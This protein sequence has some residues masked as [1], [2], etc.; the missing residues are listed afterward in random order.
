[1]P[2]YV[3]DH[4]RP[5]VATDI[6]ILCLDAGDLRVLLV[7]RGAEPFRG[8]WALPGGFLQESEDLDAC[9][10]RETRE[11]TGVRPGRILQFAN[12]SQPG[13]DPRGRVIS[14]AYLAL[15]R[16]GDV[17]L[18]AGSDAAE[19]EWRG[20][21]EARGLAFDHD[22]ILAA[23]LVRLSAEVRADP[24]FLFP[25]MPPAFTLARLQAGYEAALGRPVDKRN[26]RKLMEDS[27]RVQALEA[28][29]RGPH[30]PARLYAPLGD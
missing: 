11:E 8:D 18:K 9:A 21:A 15:V 6:V 4:P 22:A 20:L 24:A 14:V 16:A 3:Y 25:L 1:M 10:R 28:F 30:R 29:E 13:R 26:F 23:A 19:A 27:G 17:R 12:F 2:A 7:R 5:A